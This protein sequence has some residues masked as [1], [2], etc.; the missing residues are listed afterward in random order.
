MKSF[1]V[2]LGLFVV[3]ILLSGCVANTLNLSEQE[4][5]DAIKKYPRT[6]L[7]LQPDDGVGMVTAKVFTRIILWPITIGIS[8]GVLLDERNASFSKYSADLNAQRIKAYY[9]SF[10]NK[11]KHVVIKEFGPPQRTFPDGNNGEVYIYEK[12]T[13]TGGHSYGNQNYYSHTPIRYHKSIKEFY[14]NAKG[15]CYLWKTDFIEN[16]TP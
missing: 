16:T 5:A 7:N 8:E 2:A 14:F 3:I 6:G 13:T 10:L 4:Q 11:S 15:I 9:D 12:I 1:I